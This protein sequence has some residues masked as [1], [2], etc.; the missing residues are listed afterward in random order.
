MTEQEFKE[1]IRPFEERACR[2]ALLPFE[3]RAAELA[4]VP[5]EIRA[6]SWDESL[7]PRDSKGKFKKK[8]V[9]LFAGG[10]AGAKGIDKSSKSGIIKSSDDFE[11]ISAKGPNEFKKGFE[12]NNLVD[13]WYGSENAH[14]H[15]AEYP[16]FTM[17]QYADR[18]LT[19]IQ[20]PTSSTILGY[21]TTDGYVVRYDKI[22]KDFVKGKPSKG[23]ITMFKAKEEYFYNRKKEE[24]EE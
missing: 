8:D 7:H 14:S 21:K 3:I 6:G 17:E 11:Y 22:Q 13:H 12:K 20:Q 23:I 9:K 1:Y 10:E 16:Y 4:L 5:Y 2:L 15:K 19:L 18:A 24:S